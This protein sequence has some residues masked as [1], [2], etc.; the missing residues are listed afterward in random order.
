MRNAAKEDLVGRDEAVERDDN[1]NTGLREYLDSIYL[2]SLNG[3]EVLIYPD[4]K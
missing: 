2:V 3:S 4:G 1:N